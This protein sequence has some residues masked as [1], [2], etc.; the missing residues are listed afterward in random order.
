MKEE[1]QRI[2][3]RKAHFSEVTLSRALEGELITLK[4][5][6]DAPAQRSSPDVKEK[7]WTYSA[8]MSETGLQRHRVYID[9]TSFN[10]WIKRT[11]GRGID[12][13]GE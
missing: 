4:M 8:W 7:R 11:Y 3:P 2:W 9:E 6:R 5:S 10:L 1:V 13:G 12:V